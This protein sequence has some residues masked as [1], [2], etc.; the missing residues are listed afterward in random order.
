MNLPTELF[1]YSGC[2][3]K[4]LVSNFHDKHWAASFGYTTI[5]PHGLWFSVEDYQD[6]QNWKTWCESEEFRLSSLKYKYKVALKSPTKVLLLSTPEEI[7]NFGLKYAGNDV[8]EFYYKS[9]LK[10]MGYPYKPYVYLL[11]FEEIMKEYDGLIIAPYQWSCRLANECNWYYGWDC[12][13]GCIWNLDA[14]ESFTL[15][16]ISDKEYPVEE[17]LSWEEIMK[18]MGGFSFDLLDKNVK[19]TDGMDKR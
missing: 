18:S 17:E 4:E 12:A 9:T 13:S 8:E 15:D 10:K 5:K 19:V 3:V 1:H 7:I 11:K 6:D 14:V 16:S 2:E